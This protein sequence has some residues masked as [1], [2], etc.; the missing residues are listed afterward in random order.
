MRSFS[1]HSRLLPLTMTVIALL[2][3]EKAVG[4]A[5]EATMLPAQPTATTAPAAPASQIGPTAAPSLLSGTTPAVSQA[6]LQTL[7][8]LRRRRQLLDEREHHLDERNDLLQ[9]AELKLQTRLAELTALQ[10]RL[11]QVEDARHKRDSANWSGL[12]KTYEDMKARDAAAIFDV[13][14]LSVMLEVLDRMDERK[15]A[16]ILAGMLPERARLATQM[17]AQKRTRQDIVPAAGST[18]ALSPEDRHS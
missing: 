1:R 16:A 14:D 12:V 10:Q 18:S 4:L 5:R 15:A 3:T 7:Q 17:L 13:L 11:E 6:E 8:D 2:F 9:S